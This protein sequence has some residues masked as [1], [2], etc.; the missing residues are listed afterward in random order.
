MPLV[1]FDFIEGRTDEE[2]EKILDVAHDAMIEAFGI[3][4]RDRFQIV[5]EHKPSRLRVEGTD[6][7]LV[8]S[9]DIMIVSVTTHQR[10]QA[11]KLHFNG[12][13]CHKLEATCGIAKSDVVI[14]YIVNAHE[15]WSFGDG[16]PQ[17]LNG[18]IPPLPV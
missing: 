8:R 5:N 15:D 12:L 14:N 16:E 6:L 10:P 3:S 9:K 1:R 18:K 7:C 4:S 2:V 13:L 17:Y 11:E